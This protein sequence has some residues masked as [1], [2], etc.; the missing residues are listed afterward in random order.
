MV[1]VV[2]AIGPQDLYAIRARVECQYHDQTARLRE[3]A[4]VCQHL[5]EAHAVVGHL[6]AMA[7]TA[8]KSSPVAIPASVHG[9][10][11]QLASLRAALERGRASLRR[12]GLP[13]VAPAELPP[14]PLPALR[15]AV[16]DAVDALRTGTKPTVCCPCALRVIAY[17]W[18]SWAQSNSPDAEKPQPSI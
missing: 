16:A 4:V 9:I 14:P 1:V 6:A 10:S 8:V 15:P 3:H 18:L 2:F 17:E 13:A 7:H 12:E 5:R 11:T